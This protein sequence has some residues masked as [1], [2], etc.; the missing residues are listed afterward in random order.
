MT[1]I[2]L[3]VKQLRAA[4]RNNPCCRGLR[5]HTE[6]KTDWTELLLMKDGRLL[7]RIRLDEQVLRDLEIP[8]WYRFSEAWEDILEPVLTEWKDSRNIFDDRFYAKHTDLS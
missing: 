6:K 7:C 4:I 8:V 3:L 1:N 2:T 5:V